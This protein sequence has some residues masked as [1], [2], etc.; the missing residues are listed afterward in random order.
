GQ[1]PYRSITEHE[2][3]AGDRSTTSLEIGAR[4]LRLPVHPEAHV[5]GLPLLGSHVG[6]DAA[7][8]LLATG[9]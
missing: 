9:L 3:E 5:Y 6:A 8:C 4:R 1:L 2:L 7:A